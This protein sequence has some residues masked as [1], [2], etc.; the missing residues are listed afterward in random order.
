MI[1]EL[2]DNLWN[3]WIK[4]CAP[5]LVIQKKWHTAHRNLRPGD[6]VLIVEKDSLSSEYRIAMVDKAYPGEDG[7][8]RK[9]DLSY[10]NYKV[11]EI[12]T[13]YSGAKNQV[14]SRSVQRLAL[15]VPVDYD[16]DQ[17]EKDLDREIIIGKTRT[18]DASQETQDL[19]KKQRPCTRSKGSSQEPQALRKN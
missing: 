9:V 1:Q 2:I 8:V 5:S 16:P 7:K 19:H 6:V 4:L 12:V 13:E 11:G 18:V 14:V 3:Q 10:K 17:T 15:I